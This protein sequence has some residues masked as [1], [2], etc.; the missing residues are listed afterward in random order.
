RLQLAA[1]A[2][3]RRLGHERAP[4]ARH[5]PLAPA[6]QRLRRVLPGEPGA[7]PASVG[8]EPPS[9]VQGREDQR[10]PDRRRPRLRQRCRARRPLAARP[11]LI[12]PRA[13]P[14]LAGPPPN[15]VLPAISRG[16]RAATSAALASYFSLLTKGRTTKTRLCNGTE[17]VQAHARRWVGCAIPAAPSAANA[18]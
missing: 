10:R 11:A 15:C 1:H 8:R 18:A 6:Q 12:G 16:T 5:R 3:P 7:Q 13:G 14:R 17:R 2:R 9:R 4:L